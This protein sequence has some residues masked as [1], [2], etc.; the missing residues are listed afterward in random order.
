MCCVV[1]V[2]RDA[3]VS[4]VYI[5]RVT[6]TDSYHRLFF[7]SIQDKI[8]FSLCHDRTS[9]R[10]IAAVLVRFDLGVFIY[11]FLRFSSSCSKFT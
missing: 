9:A 1:V 10:I 3:S 11:Y 6:D 7:F 5:C 4:E 8:L 2:L